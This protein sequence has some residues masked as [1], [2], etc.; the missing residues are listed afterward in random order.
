[1]ENHDL[2]FF[3]LGLTPRRNVTF[4]LIFQFSPRLSNACLQSE[5]H[6]Y[7]E[8]QLVQKQQT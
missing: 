6:S 2:D 5:I 1:M 8:L 4:F 7:T 3:F